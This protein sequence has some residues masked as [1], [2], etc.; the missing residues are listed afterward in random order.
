MY[1]SDVSAAFD[2]VFTRRLVAKLSARGMPH[3]LLKLMTSW[4]KT[5]WAH[6]LVGGARAQRIDLDNMVFQGTVWGPILWN[7]FHPDASSALHTT[8]FDEIVL[9][10]T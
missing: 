10:T 9:P 4:L 6:V 5:R 3:N 7:V 8:G 1:M 2:R